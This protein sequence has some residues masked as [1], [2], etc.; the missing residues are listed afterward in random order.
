MVA[1]GQIEDLAE[2]LSGRRFTVLGG[3][4]LSTESGIPDYRGQGKKPT[5]IQLRP[6][7]HDA[8]VRRRY[9]ARSFA[10]WPWFSRRAPNQ[11]HL[12]LARLQRG[13]R[14][15][16]VITQNVDRLHQKAGSEGVL[17]LH[18]ALFEVRCLDC[19]AVETRD[20]LQE[21]LFTLNPEWGLQAAEAAPDGD[22]ELD[23]ARARRFCAAGCLAC[24]GRLKPDV[25]FFGEG[26]PKSRVESALRWLKESDGL[27]VLGSSLAVFSG[28]RFVRKA[29]E[30]KLPVCILNQGPTRGDVLADLKVEA[31]LGESLS[32]LDQW[33]S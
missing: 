31:S 7:V 8:E 16:G 25:V 27:L 9:W 13:G 15:G 12:A 19:G 18:G 28:F 3:A 17:E 6:F 14:V 33:L 11:G 1:L 5:S 24:G 32:R 4:G 2:Q 26:V 10:G 23:E 30:L 22:V 20:A 21:R 29:K